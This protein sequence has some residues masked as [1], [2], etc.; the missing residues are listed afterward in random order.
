MSPPPEPADTAQPQPCIQLHS[1]TC[2]HQVLPGGRLTCGR[3]KMSPPPDPADTARPKRR[4][5]PRPAVHSPA[6][7]RSVDVLPAPEG[8]TTSSDRPAR[9]CSCRLSCTSVS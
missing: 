8:P 1:E 2:I 5:V 7:T 4:T 9:T 6:T 3:K